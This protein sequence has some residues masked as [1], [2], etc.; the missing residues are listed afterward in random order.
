MKIVKGHP[1][2]YKKITDTFK[3][4]KNV[5]FTYGDTLYSPGDGE[6][7]AHLMAHEERHSI[8][9]AKMGVEEWWDKY[10]EDE[11]FRLEQELEAYQ[12]QYVV[13]KER[14][15][16]AYRR[17]I[18]KKISKDLASPMYGSIISTEEA[19]ELITNVG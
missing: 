18:L 12:D 1:P 9:Q 13:L 6:I 16:R 15:G 4:G 10:L 17:D 8:Q 7:P 19:K 5:V 11:K 14:Y 2:N 3:I